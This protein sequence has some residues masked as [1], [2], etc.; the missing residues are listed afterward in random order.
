MPRHKILINSVAIPFNLEFER[1][2]IQ[3]AACIFMF[4]IYFFD[5]H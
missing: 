4:E 3:R 2:N 1:Y 5:N